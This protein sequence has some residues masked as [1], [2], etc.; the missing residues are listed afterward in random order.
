MRIVLWATFAKAEIIARLKPMLGEGLVVVASRDELARAAPGAA[1]VL[2]PDFHYDA[3]VAEI[4]RHRAEQLRWLGL[5]TAGYEHAQ[6]HGVP[7]HVVVTNAADAYSPAVAVHAVSMLLALHRRLPAILANQAKHAWQ[8]AVSAEASTPA[9]TTIAVIGFGSIGREVARLVRTFGARVIG[10]ARSLR[11]EPHADE[12]ATLAKL[13]DLLPQVDA[14]VLALPL[15]PETRRLIGRRELALCKPN[16]IIVNISR[17]GIIDTEALLDALRRGTIGGA[18]LDVTDP[19]PL[20]AD[21]PLWDAPNLIITPHLAGAAGAAGFERLATV[22]AGNVERFLA[23]K[24]LAH[25]IDLH[26]ES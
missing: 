11:K 2:T 24:P 16:A 26:G 14:I 22:A 7:P 23:G 21:H 20:P 25:V 12:M 3:A 4:L 10:V 18:G 15:G 17:G 5:L 1:A 8:R 6:R 9:G 13:P 19:E